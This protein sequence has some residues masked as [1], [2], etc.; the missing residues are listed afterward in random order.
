MICIFSCRKN[1]EGHVAGWEASIHARGRA[2][3]GPAHHRLSQLQVQAS[4]EEA[5]EE[6]PQA[7]G[8]RRPLRSALPL[9][10]WLHDAQQPR[11]AAAEPAAVL[12]QHAPLLQ[13]PS[14]HWALAWC[15]PKHANVFRHSSSRVFPQPSSDVPKPIPRRVCRRAVSWGSSEPHAVR[16]PQPRSATC[17]S[18]GVAVLWELAVSARALAGVLPGTGSAGY[19]VRPGPQRVWTVPGPGP[20]QAWVC[21]SQQLPSTERPQR[22][23]L[24]L[25][26]WWNCVFI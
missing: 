24:A 12:P 15:L 22:G 3:E 7:S 11:S 25:L 26:N 23:P 9:H 10:L 20:K 4:Q 1:V 16:F 21:G 14:S 6:E 5:A 18:G 8:C 2:S 13:L 19:A 17:G